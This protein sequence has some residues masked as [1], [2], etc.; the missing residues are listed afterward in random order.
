[1]WAA[2]EVEASPALAFL[3]PRQRLEISPRDAERLGLR[4][5]EHVE[6]AHAGRLP[7]GEDDVAPIVHA[8]V[9]LRASVPT[10][11]VFLEEGVP[12][13][14]ANALTNGGGPIAVDVRPRVEPVPMLATVGDLADEDAPG[15]ASEPDEQ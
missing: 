4:E 14:A 15:D 8:I 12:E 11:V 13:Q 10:G 1:M 5:G 6:V 9:A 2:P 7:S 3:H